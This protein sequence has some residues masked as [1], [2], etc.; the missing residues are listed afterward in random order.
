MR[1]SFPIFVATTTMFNMVGVSAGGNQGGG[2]NTCDVPYVGAADLPTAN[3]LSGPCGYSSKW[4]FKCGTTVYYCGDFDKN[5]DTVPDMIC[6]SQP[7][8][9]D[10]LIFKDGGTVD[11]VDIAFDCRYMIE[12]IVARPFDG[13]IKCPNGNSISDYVCYDDPVKINT[14]PSGSPGLIETNCCIAPDPTPAPTSLG[15]K[16]PTS[17]PTRSPTHAPTVASCSCGITEDAA[18]WKCGSYVYYCPSRMSVCNLSVLDGVI[19]VALDA[20]QCTVMNNAHTGMY[21]GIVVIFTVMG[22]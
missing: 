18:S 5:A 1:L 22:S 13:S 7:L 21:I 12:N 19:Y 17:A 6:K 8:P 10:F 16:A 20:N 14:T 15:T 3:L 11:V 4:S 2:G 9:G